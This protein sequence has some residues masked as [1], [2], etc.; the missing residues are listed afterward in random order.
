MDRIIVLSKEGKISEIG[1]YEKLISDG[2]NFS[3][4]IENEEK[5]IL[6]KNLENEKKEKKENEEKK[7]S[8]NERKEKSKSSTEKKKKKKEQ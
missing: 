2:L 8:K 7:Y 6:E 1:T 4:L 3:K 5:N